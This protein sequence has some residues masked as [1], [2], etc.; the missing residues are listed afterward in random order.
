MYANDKRFN[1]D[2]KYK[3]KFLFGLYNQGIHV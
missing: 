3:N 2:S 1:M